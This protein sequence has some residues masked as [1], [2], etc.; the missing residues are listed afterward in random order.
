LPVPIDTLD[1]AR[2][3][4]QF[5]LSDQARGD[6]F[7]ELYRRYSDRLLG[8]LTSRAFAR[9]E[10]EEIAGEAWVRAW[11][12]LDRYEYREGLGFFPWLR[13]IADNVAREFDRKHYLSRGTVDPGAE[14]EDTV[15]D[16]LAAD[17]P[18]VHLTR[19]EMRHAIQ[20]LLLEIPNGDW[21]IVIE[22]HLLDQWEPSDIM[23]LH[24]WSRSKVDVTKLR[25]L[26]WLKARLLETVGPSHIEAWLGDR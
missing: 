13:K 11:E 26:A 1:D 20:Q 5:H 15:A 23:E 6:A 21:Q 25:A 8:Y 10:R 2:L 3:A 9:S 19:E 7:D 4:E 17:E 14:L 16:E 18:I 24:G 22:E 12:R